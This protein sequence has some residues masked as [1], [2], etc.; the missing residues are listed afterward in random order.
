VTEIYGA[1]NHTEWYLRR[2]LI[3]MPDMPPAPLPSPIPD[4]FLS[5]DFVDHFAT[6]VCQPEIA[7]LEAE[8]QFGV[9]KA[10]QVQ[11]RSL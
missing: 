1:K 7:A 9:V 2:I 3:E 4:C 8:G 6:H 11:D 5:E 10:Q